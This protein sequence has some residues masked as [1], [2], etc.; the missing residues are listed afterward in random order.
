MTYTGEVVEL[1]STALD[2][3]VTITNIRRKG[4]PDW[5]E[6]GEPI[7]LLLPRHRTPKIGAVV[8]ITMTPV[9]VRKAR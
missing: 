4:C 1:R 3:R 7:T 2:V 5:Y 8:T 9:R 6:Y